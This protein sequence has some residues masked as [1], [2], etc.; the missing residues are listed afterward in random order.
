MIISR[1]KALIMQHAA[2]ISNPECIGCQRSICKHGGGM[3][4]LTETLI[5]VM[6]DS[7]VVCWVNSPIRESKKNAVMEALL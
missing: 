7:G 5:H 6:Q 2:L 4:G 3:G 1:V